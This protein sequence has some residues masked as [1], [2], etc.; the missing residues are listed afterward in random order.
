VYDHFSLIL[1]VCAAHFSLDCFMNLS[2]L[3]R[4]GKEAV[5]EGWVE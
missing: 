3:Y 5:I 1:T 4:L 2:N